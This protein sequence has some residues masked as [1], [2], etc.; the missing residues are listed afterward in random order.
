[1]KRILA[2][3]ALTLGF[4][5]GLDA[6][7]IRQISVIKHS[8]YLGL[9]VGW[10]N[11]QSICDPVSNACWNFGE[12]P[13][14][15]A[16]LEMPLSPATTIGVS[17]GNAKVPLRW[18]DTPPNTA[19]CTVCDANG[20][21]NQI[22]GLMHLG[23]TGAFQQLIDISAG[24]TQFGNFKTTAGVPLGTGKRVT[25]FTF[26]IG[27]GFGIR[28]SEA[29]LFTVQQEY[30]LVIHKRVPGS[31]SSSAQQQAFRLGLRIGL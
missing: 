29:W 9:S 19:N 20:E 26:G 1:M 30:G 5:S 4:T 18:A 16:S 12:A 22:M 10:L 21:M 31:P 6:Q 15:R 28:M 11:T 2:A 27:F 17:Y 23:G 24:A 25:D 8:A 14:Y 7:I 13:Q 3:A